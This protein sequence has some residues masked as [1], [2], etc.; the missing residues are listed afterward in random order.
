MTILGI[1]AFYHDS[2]AAIIIDGKVIV[3]LEEER[4]SRVK[5]DNQFPFTAINRALQLAN[6]SMDAIDAI[7]YY[8]KPLRKFERI[9]ETFVQTYPHALKPFIKTIPEWLGTKL[10][11]EHIIRNKLHFNKQIFFVPH[12]LSH[13]AASFY[14]SPFHHAAILTV[15]GVGEYETTALWHATD[16]PIQ[17]LKYINF[18]DSIGL[19]YS[20]FTA[21]LGFKINEDEYKVMGLAAYGKPSYE[22]R[23]RQLVDVK[24]DGSFRLNQR[25]FGYRTSFCM[26]NRHFETLFGKPRKSHEIVEKRHKDIAHSLQKVTEEILFT[27]LRHLH[28]ITKE[29]N[30]CIGGGVALNALANGKIYTNT[31]FKRVHILGSSSDSSTSVGA[32]LYC[33]YNVLGKG[34]HTE[35]PTLSL[36]TNYDDESI[37]RILKLYPITYEK[38]TDEQRMLKIVTNA[39]T[40][41]KIVGWFKG[42]MEFGPRALGNRSILSATNPYGMKTRVNVI[43]RREQFRPFAGSVLQNYVSDY[44]IV[45]EKKHKSSYMN[46][47]FQV[48]ENKQMQLAAI[49]HKDKTCR[50]QTVSEANGTY[51][52]LLKMYYKKTGIPCILNTSFNLKGDPIVETPRQALETFLKTSMHMLI[53]ND[54]MIQRLVK[55]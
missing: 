9:I 36:G 45:P 26:W 19:L 20:T 40:H 42:A 51:Y 24:P 4:F 5:H 31:P 22:N 38:I 32:A 1:S 41:K 48:K 54:Y 21:F 43:K 39:L 53:M 33:Y 35:L 44:F 29:G 37:E 34:T 23:I 3:A 30:L 49:V 25:Y 10:S 28:E 8:E 16:K 27:M 47:C 46:F 11:V 13:A 2:A 55:P 14:T 15:D 18:P 6:L 52:R 7:A 12:H 50:I 17:Q